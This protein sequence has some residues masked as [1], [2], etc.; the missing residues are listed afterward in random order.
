MYLGN[1]ET[2]KERFLYD[3]TC[4]QSTLVVC[5]PSPRELRELIDWASRERKPFQRALIPWSNRHLTYGQFVR[6]GEPDD[7]EIIANLKN[8]KGRIA[9]SNVIQPCGFNADPNDMLWPNFPEDTV[10][11]LISEAYSSMRR[12]VLPRLPSGQTGLHDLLKPMG[13]LNSKGAAALAHWHCGVPQDEFMSAFRMNDLDSTMVFNKYPLGMTWDQLRPIIHSFLKN[14]PV[15]E[16]LN[17]PL[18]IRWFEDNQVKVGTVTEFIHL[19]LNIQIPMAL[20]KADSNVNGSIAWEYRSMLFPSFIQEEEE[21]GERYIE[22]SPLT[23]VEIM[24]TTPLPFPEDLLETKLKDMRPKQNTKD[25]FQYLLNN[26]D[27]IFK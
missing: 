10:R 11:W 6:D 26:L 21:N 4:L 7:C 19:W 24:K 14:E 25:E 2:Y 23:P 8:V 16:P 17:M 27:N 1:C 18:K 5:N 9:I 3:E 15:K 20:Q 12:W 13:R 22:R